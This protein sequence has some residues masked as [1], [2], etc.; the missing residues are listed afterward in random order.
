[1]LARFVAL[2]ILLLPAMAWGEADLRVSL[3]AG[4]EYDNN[5]FRTSDDQTQDVLFRIGPRI[6]FRDERENLDYNFSYRLP[7]SRGFETRQDASFDQFF[8]GGLSY[9]FT[10]RT[11]FT[12]ED[13]FAWIRSDRAVQPIDDPDAPQINTGD[14][15]ILR[16]N[17]NASLEHLFTNRLTGTLGVASSLFTSDRDDRREVQT[18]NGAGNLSYALNSKHRIGG[19]ASFTHQD[20]A[21]LPEQPGSTTDIYRVFASW[22][23]RIDETLSFS[24][25]GGPTWI[26]TVQNGAAALVANNNPAGFGNPFLFTRV[27]DAGFANGVPIDT[28]GNGSPDIRINNVFLPV[29]SLIIAT[30]QSCGVLA[31]STP[32]ISPQPSCN[33]GDYSVIPYDTPSNQA[34]VDAIVAD[35]S[36]PFF[37]FVDPPGA[38]TSQQS[39]QFTYFGSASLNKRW[40]PRVSSGLSYQRSE[41]SASGVGGSTILDA[42]TANLNFRYSSLWN[43]ALRADWTNRTSV[44]P[45]TSTFRTQQAFDSGATVVPGGE[46]PFLAEMT[47]ERVFRIV[48]TEINTNRWAVAGRTSRRIT[49]RLEANLRLAYNQQSSQSGTRGS[50]SDFDDVTLI[51]GVNYLFDPVPL[52]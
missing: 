14:E 37:A 25:R 8:T 40:S 48:N 6:R 39:T 4:V 7:Y 51:M 10:P 3:A 46:T 32:V 13:R 23:Y 43:F 30:E 45:T 20:F 35:G 19:G 2:V 9:R 52:W 12:M 1:M 33:E 5:V 42:V 38:P 44:A 24:I 31:P 11:S 26:D 50:S 17:L 15:R 18:Y 36:V 29:D 41:S 27:T 22:M 16:N 47:G 28:D 21:D 49:R 34:I